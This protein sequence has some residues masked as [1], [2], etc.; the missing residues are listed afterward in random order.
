M[1][2]ENKSRVGLMVILVSFPLNKEKGQNILAQVILRRH[3][4]QQAA[5]KIND[6]LVYNGKQSGGNPM[7][8]ESFQK[9]SMEVSLSKCFLFDSF[10]PGTYINQ[11]KLIH[12]IG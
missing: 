7:C 4:L 6:P 5:V 11:Q 3:V 12:K 10:C 8:K 9:H 2:S 1:G